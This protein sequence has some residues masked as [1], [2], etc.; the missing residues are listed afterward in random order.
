MNRPGGGCVN[1]AAARFCGGC[2]TPLQA[3]SDSAPKA[4]RWAGPECHLLRLCWGK[5]LSEPIDPGDLRNLLSIYHEICAEAVRGFEGCLSP[6]MG[7]GVVIYF[8]YS[9]ADEDDEVRALRCSLAIKDGV[10]ALAAMAAIPFEVRIGV[11]RGCVVVG[12]LAGLS[13]E[14]VVSDA[15]W[16]LV[17]SVFL[18]EPAPME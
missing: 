3:N 6:L 14:V 12:A 9:I 16:R 8:G 10:K 5:A 13:G 4:E 15:I 1:Q 11:H 17:S 2:A 18:A 7:D